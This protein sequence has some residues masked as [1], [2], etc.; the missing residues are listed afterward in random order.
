MKR[1][2]FYSVIRLLDLGVHVK[3]N[4]VLSSVLLNFVIFYFSHRHVA[5]SF[6]TQKAK[7]ENRG[8][9]DSTAVIKY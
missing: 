5:G 1:K 4:L 9:V 3:C 2:L 8:A 7:M 6:T